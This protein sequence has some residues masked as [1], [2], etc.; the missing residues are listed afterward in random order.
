MECILC[1]MEVIGEFIEECFTVVFNHSV[2]TLLPLH[3][4][5][6]EKASEGLN[7]GAAFLRSNKTGCYSRGIFFYFPVI[8][9]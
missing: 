9:L 4:F 8:S 1:G 3:A 5:E 7:V 6:G 2:V